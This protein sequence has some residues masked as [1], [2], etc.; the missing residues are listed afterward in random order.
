MALAPIEYEGA[1]QAMMHALFLEGERPYFKARELSSDKVVN[2]YY[3]R[4]LYPDVV[5]VLERRRAVVHIYGSVKSSRLDKHVSEMNVTK[6]AQAERMT[7]EELHRLFGVAPHLTGELST[8]DFM[9]TVRE[10]G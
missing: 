8:E 1:I 6:I 2:C 9:D 4:N 10:R 3:A 7:T 5:R